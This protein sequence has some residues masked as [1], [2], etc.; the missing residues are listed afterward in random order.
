MPKVYLQSEKL[1]DRK[2]RTVRDRI[3]ESPHLHQVRVELCG[4]L[5]ERVAPKSFPLLGIGIR[6]LCMRG[7]SGGPLFRLDVA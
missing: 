7:D 4:R 5:G 2:S 3:A 6:G 1:G